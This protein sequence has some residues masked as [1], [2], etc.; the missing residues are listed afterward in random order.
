MLALVDP[1]ANRERNESKQIMHALKK[2]ASQGKTIVASV[3]NVSN[4]VL[5][6]FDRL[7]VL[8]NQG[9]IYNGKTSEISDFLASNNIN[10]ENSSPI[11]TLMK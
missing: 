11:E 8:S 9:V 1:F 6:A 5:E 10:C 7:Y 2:E 3:G 4:E